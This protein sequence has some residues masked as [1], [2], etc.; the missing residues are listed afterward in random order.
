MFITKV[1]PKL[2]KAS[3]NLVI[4]KKKNIY[5]PASQDGDSRN[6]DSAMMVARLPERVHLLREHPGE[7][8]IASSQILIYIKLHFKQI[9]L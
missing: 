6:G 5:I 4:K 3:H 8:L 2:V 7:L 9:K 1:Y